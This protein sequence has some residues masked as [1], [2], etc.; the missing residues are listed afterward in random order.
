MPQTFTHSATT[1][2]DMTAVW[3]ELD[4]PS[5]WQGIPGVQRVVDPQVDGEGRLRGFAFET[6]IGGTVYRGTANPAGR[7]EGRMMSW[8]IASSELVGNITV[9]LTPNG[10]GTEVGVDL[11]AEGAGLLGSML[12]PVIAAAIGNGFTGTVEDFVSGL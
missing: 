2:K 12:F 10:E 9:R 3:A 5:T 11:E 7:E 1:P 6:R 4:K 8:A